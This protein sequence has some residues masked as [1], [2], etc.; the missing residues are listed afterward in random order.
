MRRKTWFETMKRMRKEAPETEQTFFFA[1][2][3]FS[4]AFAAL[5]FSSSAEFVV[6]EIETAQAEFKEIKIKSSL[7]RT[8]ESMTFGH[9]MEV[10]APYLAQ[11]DPVTA[12]FLVAIAKQESNWGSRSPRSED[13]RDCYNYW[14][15]RGQT[16]EVTP[17]GY[18]CFQSPRQAVRIVGERLNRLI[19]EYDLDTPRELLVW[20]CGSSCEGH[21]Q[22][23]VAR[24]QRTVGMY[25][26]KI[27]ADLAL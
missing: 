2:L 16:E 24:W 4:A 27:E 1:T 18:S 14:G 26:K 22:D 10:M 19:Y 12:T 3:L 7:E 5:L 15:Y 9:P 17:S 20:K 13:G 11:R 23:D 8:L 21:D 6:L 25:S